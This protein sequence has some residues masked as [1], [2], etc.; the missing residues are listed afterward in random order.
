M[1]DM[2]FIIASSPSPSYIYIYIY[3][4][5]YKRTPLLL[6]REKRAN[7]KLRTDNNP[8]KIGRKLLYVPIL[9]RVNKL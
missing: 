9:H 5:I 8:R 6:L 4:Y 1:K 7:M 2:I 3:I